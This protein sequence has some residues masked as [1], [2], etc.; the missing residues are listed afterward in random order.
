MDLA[1]WAAERV[2]ADGLFATAELPVLY[3]PAVTFSEL[4]SGLLFALLP[5]PIPNMVLWFRPEV[6]RTVAWAGEPRKLTQPASQGA[7]SRLSPRNSFEAWKVL[8]RNHSAPWMP[9]ELHAARELRRSAIELDLSAQVIRAEMAVTAR[10]ELVAVVSHDLRNPLSAV[11]LSAL[12]LVRTLVN[13]TSV[14]A[15]RQLAAAQSI[16]RA[17]ARMDQMLR[18]LLDLATI[19]QG[20][21]DIK[22]SS[23]PVNTLFEDAGALLMPIAESK[24]VTLRFASVDGLAVR[25]DQERFHQVLSNLVVNSL[26]FTREGGGVEVCAQVD[27]SSDGRM[28]RFSVK[29]TGIGMSTEQQSH[30]FERY[31]RVREANPTGTGLGLYIARGLVEAHGGTIRV[32]SEVGKGTTMYFTL[33]NAIAD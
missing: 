9:H 1:R 20:R 10:D 12:L 6:A 32:E 19:E 5:K 30:I 29:D 24:R 2:G 28:L 13:D 33:Q 25:T 15:R 31:W 3:E 14:S 23:C 4:A 27:A 18:D 16:Q 11:S 8:V 26:K 7:V 21:Y 22:L 17:A